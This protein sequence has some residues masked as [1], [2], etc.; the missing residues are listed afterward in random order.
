MY[1]FVERNVENRFESMS[2]CIAKAHKAMTSSQ[3]SIEG[4]HSFCPSK[5]IRIYKELGNNQ[6]EWI[7]FLTDTN[8]EVYYD[9]K[10]FIETQ[11]DRSWQERPK[12]KTHQKTK[13]Q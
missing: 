9:Y 13:S 1:L 8:T 3:K 7:G 2:E 12:K 6:Y 5:E 4:S 10:A 11:R